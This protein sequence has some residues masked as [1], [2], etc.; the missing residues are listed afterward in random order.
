MRILFINLVR[1]SGRWGGL[2]NNM[3]KEGQYQEILTES[4]SS[5]LE[6][7]K[8]HRKM[9]NRVHLPWFR[10]AF[11]N[12]LVTY[13]NATVREHTQRIREEIKRLPDRQ[14]PPSQCFPA[15]RGLLS[16]GITQFISTPNILQYII[17]IMSTENM[18]KAQM[19]IRQATRAK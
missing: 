6:T 9:S 19:K 8:N 14:T 5:S 11:V 4:A 15:P 2:A 17:T 18:A 10:C 3:E 12:E 13:P 16:G 1:F 7:S